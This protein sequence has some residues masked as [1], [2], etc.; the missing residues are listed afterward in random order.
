[1][2]KA[3]KLSIIFFFIVALLSCVTGDKDIKTPE[4][5]SS[6]A[7]EWKSSQTPFSVTINASYGFHFVGSK[8]LKKDN[9]IYKYSV[10]TNDS[11][12]IIY[13]IDWKHTTWKFDKGADIFE[14]GDVRAKGLLS[15]QPYQFTI[16]TGISQFSNQVLTDMGIQVPECKVALNAGR[17][18]EDD[19]ST[20][21]F[22]VFIEK[23]N[24]QRSDYEDIIDLYND[25][26]FI[27]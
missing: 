12:G 2:V 19:T 17:L 18:N 16:W 15:H 1:M 26:I 9:K 21:V 3:F 6:G 5:T 27:W 14:P 20:A 24:C 10:F 11:G 23:W 7:I 22:V 4:K 13:I 8:N 25:V